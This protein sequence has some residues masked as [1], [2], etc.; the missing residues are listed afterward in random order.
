MRVVIYPENARNRRR[1]ERLRLSHLIRQ[2]HLLAPLPKL[3]PLP[4]NYKR[5]DCGA[6]AQR[7]VVTTLRGAKRADLNE[8]RRHNMAAKPET[9]TGR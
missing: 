2:K 5:V 7:S 4:A 1:R 6:L 8:L 3:V 9:D